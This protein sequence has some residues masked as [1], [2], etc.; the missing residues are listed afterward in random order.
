[1]GQPEG[2]TVIPAPREGV[3]DDVIRVVDWIV[4]DGTRVDEGDPVATLETTKA[5]FDVAATRSGFLHRLVAAG[6]EV[7]VGAPLALVSERPE[8]PALPA[9]SSSTTHRSAAGNQVVTKKALELIA[10]HGLAIDE[11]AGLSVVRSQDVEALLSRR[12]ETLRRRLS[13]SSAA[14]T[15]TAARTGTAWS[16]TTSSTRSFRDSWTCCESG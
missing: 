10:Q 7:P 2:Y 12:A 16:R 4:S 9:D 8:R 13:A 15:S 6:A 1:M 11:L 5:T 14:R 3:N